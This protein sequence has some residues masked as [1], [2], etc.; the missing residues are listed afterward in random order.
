MTGRFLAAIAVLATTAI[1]AAD[2]VTMRFVNPGPGRAVNIR[3][4]GEQHYVHAGQ[5]NHQILSRSG[6]SAPAV[7]MLATYCVDVAEWVS[8]QGVT[9]D[10]RE[11]T[12]APVAGGN[13]GMD[14][15][16]AAAIARLYTYAN[17]QQFSTNNNF[18][19]AFQLAIWEIVADMDTDSTTLSINDGDFRAWGLNGGTAGHLA[20][21]LA[22][23]T[24]H[25]IAI[26]SRLLALTNDGA[27]DQLFQVAVPLP[28]TGAL[29][30]VGLAG[31]GLLS[32]RR[33][34]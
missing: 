34:A 19:A 11:L 4:D 17:G 14:A 18:S 9:Y 27:Q 12:D 24:D 2:S 30:A 3:I 26:R 1:A 15:H 25:T 16:K 29:A 13:N 8:P 28:T 5:L 32:R 33:R 31:A 20:T 6:P 23:A 22:V 7:G 21:L 10:V